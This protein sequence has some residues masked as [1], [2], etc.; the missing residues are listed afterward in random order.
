MT[1]LA[2]KLTP[3]PSLSNRQCASWSVLESV[4]PTV[5]WSPVQVWR[6]VHGDPLET[7]VA[8]SSD[9]TFQ[10]KFSRLDTIGAGWLSREVVDSLRTDIESKRNEEALVAKAARSKLRWLSEDPAKQRSAIT[11]A[12]DD[13]LDMLNGANSLDLLLGFIH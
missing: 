1:I 10:R 6:L 12:L 7:L 2:S 5:G 4:L 8:A 11:A 3:V 9:E 13:A